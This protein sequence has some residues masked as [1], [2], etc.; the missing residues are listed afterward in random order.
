MHTSTEFIPMGGDSV[1]CLG[2]R[3]RET[4]RSAHGSAGLS[5]YFREE[6]D[7]KFLG[8]CHL[9]SWKCEQTVAGTLE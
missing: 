6:F 2:R 9:K 8:G 5:V 7:Q 1:F 3:T 4:S